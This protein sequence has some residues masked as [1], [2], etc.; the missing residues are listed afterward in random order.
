LVSRTKQLIKYCTEL[1]VG[2]QGW[3]QVRVAVD[4]DPA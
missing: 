1:L 2:K 4:V 3:S